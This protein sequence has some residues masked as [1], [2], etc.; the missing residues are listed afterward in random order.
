[1]PIPQ[2]IFVIVAASLSA[3]LVLWMIWIEI[4]LKRI[5]RGRRTKDLESLLANIAHDIQHIQEQLKKDGNNIA[6]TMQELEKSARHIGVVRFNAFQEAGGEQSFAVALLN[7]KKDGMVLSSLHNR[8][9]NRVY[10]KII[11]NGESS[12]HLSEEEKEAIT[13]A[14]AQKNPNSK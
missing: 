5:F 7:D 1:M 8:E 12:H 2:N 11:K 3:V 4:R 13:Q 9:S 6:L 10:A 14:L